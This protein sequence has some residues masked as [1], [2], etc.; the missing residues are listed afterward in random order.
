MSQDYECYSNNY[1]PNNYCTT[2]TTSY[3]N[4]YYYYD[5]T[6][7]ITADHTFFTAMPSITLPATGC[8]IYI[9]DNY[10]MHDPRKPRVFNGKIIYSLRRE[11]FYNKTPVIC[12]C[13]RNQVSMGDD[14]FCW[15]CEM[16]KILNLIKTKRSFEQFELEFS[17]SLTDKLIEIIF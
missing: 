9:D 6:T 12:L 17:D 15:K 8:S 2:S 14:S 10:Y 3:N 13:G 4:Y 16:K 1:I 7:T 5:T 11:E